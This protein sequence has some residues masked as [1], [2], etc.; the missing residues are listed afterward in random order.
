[1]DTAKTVQWKIRESQ[2]EQTH[3]AFA[4]KLGILIGSLACLENTLQNATLR[5]IEKI[6]RVNRIGAN[7]RLAQAVRSR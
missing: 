4:K 7:S 1:M 3:R 6:S 2:R 5:T